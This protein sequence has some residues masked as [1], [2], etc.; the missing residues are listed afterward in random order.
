MI[1]MVE[2]PELLQQMYLFAQSPHGSDD[3][4]MEAMQFIS[5]HHPLLLP[6]DKMVPMWVDGRQTDLFMLGFEITDE[7]DPIEGVSEAVLEK[8]AD[9]YDLLRQDRAAEAEALLHEIVAEAPDFCSAYNQLAVAYELQGRDEE[10]RALTEEIH[11]RFPDY[12]FARVALARMN[13]REKRIEAARELLKPLL[14]RPKLHISEFRALAS[15]QIDLALADNQI[16]VARTWLDM[17]QQID[18]DNPEL[19]EWKLR[20]EGPRQWRTILS[21]LIDQN[22]E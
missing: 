18:E 11:A 6:E 12:F 7:P 15:A 19:V 14:L 8:H 20:I 2:T 21:K 1:R 10:A 22:P 9:A 5:Q 17:W 3:L 13:A 16:E 4:H